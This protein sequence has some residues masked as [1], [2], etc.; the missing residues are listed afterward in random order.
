[1]PDH[2]SFASV[3]GNGAISTAPPSIIYSPPPKE[4]KRYIEMYDMT[5]RTL[6]RYINSYIH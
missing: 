4:S 3:A 1:M 5:G 2:D 6:L